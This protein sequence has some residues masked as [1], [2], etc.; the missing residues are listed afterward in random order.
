MVEL[1]LLIKLN[2]ISTSNLQYSEKSH[3]SILI[4][5]W[6]TAIAQCSRQSMDKLD[7]VLALLLITSMMREKL[8]N[9]KKFEFSSPL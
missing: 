3:D 9:L 8:F 6:Y 7:L 2:K 4:P 5:S 1:S